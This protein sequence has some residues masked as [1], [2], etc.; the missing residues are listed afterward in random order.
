VTPA[1]WH[2]GLAYRI[3]GFPPMIE[4]VGLSGSAGITTGLMV[5]A[6]VLPTLVLQLGGRY[7]QTDEL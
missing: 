4:S 2:F 1:K 6:S 7:R 3:L 5:G